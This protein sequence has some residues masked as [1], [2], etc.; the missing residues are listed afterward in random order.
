MCE[1]YP[2]SPLGDLL[3]LGKR[4]VLLH[5]LV[6]QPLHIGDVVVR[7]EFDRQTAKRL[8]CEGQR[9]DYDVSVAASN[10]TSFRC[11]MYAPGCS[12]ASHATLAGVKVDV[13]G[14]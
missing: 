4:C 13:R 12:L 1:E 11:D 2:E 7:P 9:L 10:I 14:G 3:R 8:H 6:N 5:Q